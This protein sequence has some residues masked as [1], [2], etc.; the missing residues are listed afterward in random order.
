MNNHNNDKFLKK[1]KDLIKTE[2]FDD[3]IVDLPDDEQIESLTVENL[4]FD[5][6]LDDERNNIISGVSQKETVSTS[7]S[8]VM[9]SDITTENNEIGDSNQSITDKTD[10]SSNNNS[11][12]SQINDGYTSSENDPQ[13]R[14]KSVREKIDD[15]KN[16]YEKAKENIE[17]APEKLQK[18][19]ENIEKAPEKLQEVKENIEKAP[20]KIRDKANNINQKINKTKDNIKK[21]PEKVKNTVNKLKQMDFNDIVNTARNFAR[22][23]FKDGIQKAATKFKKHSINKVKNGKIARRIKKT[24]KAIKLVKKVGK[25]TAKAAKKVTDAIVKFI[26]ETTPVSE[27]VIAVILVL[28]LLIGIIMCI[29]TAVNGDVKDIDEGNLSNLYSDRDAVIL[30]KLH[31]RQ[32]EYSS[33]VAAYALAIVSYP[34][35]ENLMGDN[36]LSFIGDAFSDDDIND[37]TELDEEDQEED[38]STEKD[39]IDDDP[40]LDIFAKWSFR[41]K[42]SKIMKKISNMEQDEFKDWLKKNYFPK[43]GGSY[44]SS[45]TG[46][47]VNGGYK[48]L[49]SKVKDADKE[50]FMN[51]IID[52]LENLKG[53][54]KDYTYE[55]QSCTSSSTTL[56][57]SYA[58]D[59]IQGEAVVVLKDSASGD[60]STIKSASSLYGTEDLSLDLKRYV[61]GVA[62]AESE[63]GI[64]LEASAKAIMIA[65]KSF[66]L[67]RTGPGSS[68][69][70]GKGFKPDYS[71]GKTIFYMRA[72]TADQDFCDVYEGCKSGSRYAK[73]LQKNSYGSETLINIKPKLD[74]N[75]LSNLEKWYDETASEFVYDSKNNTFAG[76]QYNDYN[77]SCKVGSCLSQNKAIQLANKGQ[78]YKAILYGDDGGAF[79]GSKYNT[80]NMTTKTLSK[81]DSVCTE[82]SSDGDCGIPDDK[83]IYYSQYDEKWKNDTFCGRTVEVCGQEK[84]ATIGEAACGV[85]SMAMVIANLTDQTSIL[86]TDTM[87]EAQSGSY[88]GCKIKGTDSRYF[89]T[90]ANKYGLTYKSLSVDKKG[91]QEALEILKSG[92][93]IIANVGSASPFTTG[94]HYIV[95]RKVDGEGN[96]YVGDPAHSGFLKKPYNINDFVN[97]GW[98]TYG[99]W[100]FTSGKSAEIVKNY[101][102]TEAKNTG[103][104]G[105]ATGI[106]IRPIKG[107]NACNYYPT[108][109]SGKWHGGGDIPTPI[110][111][112]VLAADGGI[113]ES[114]EYLNYSYGYHV[115]INHGNGYKSWY[116]HMSTMSV[117]KGE[118]VSQGQEIGKSGNTGNSSGPHLHFEVR[119]SPYS[120]TQ[121]TINVCNYIGQNK[122]YSN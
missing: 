37:E 10:L 27:I 90:A 73:E 96:V 106:F 100:G 59:I 20:E 117:K 68:D 26:A 104:K 4:N 97:K 103:E 18:A 57:Y 9:S 110:G 5:G 107:N 32:S 91:I 67:G 15:I 115:V 102:Q 11:L 43:E 31:D 48:V 94:G 46:E 47:K 19:K 87:S 99:W 61:M 83:F 22:D 95:I 89:Q 78:D 101:C 16:K 56:G 113:V 30:E 53:F 77:A 7:N 55:R 41:R 79:T 6:T 75:L 84:S 60:F 29:V 44:Q 80:F 17:K 116:G 122:K 105:N 25:T 28:F 54:F 13:N 38:I 51:A 33:D 45:S 42:Y 72:S 93:L 86:P 120:H 40:Y 119:K 49:M 2:V 36:V 62:Y 108:Y 52:D 85:T 24:K 64:R 35:N 82:I 81:E 34:Y 121:N 58:G 109:S 114:V 118:K 76:N 70:V 3:N 112:S 92:G 8:N 14:I 50:E 65:A 69:T 88:C 66:V 71:D 21:A 23:G 111:T 63:G 98:L 1:N 39:T 74:A 12:S